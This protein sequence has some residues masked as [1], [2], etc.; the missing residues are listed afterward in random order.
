MLK[1]WPD[2]LLAFI[3]TPDSLHLGDMLRRVS[4]MTAKS[5]TS[6][7]EQLTKAKQFGA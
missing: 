7:I 2:S 1:P 6:R 3:V 5:E 4:S